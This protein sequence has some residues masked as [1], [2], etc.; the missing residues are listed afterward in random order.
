MVCGLGDVL[1]HD[2]S[3]QRYSFLVVALLNFSFDCP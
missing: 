1:D 3:V 2:F